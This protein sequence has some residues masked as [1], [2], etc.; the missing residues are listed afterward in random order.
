V[1][2]DDSVMLLRK[3]NP[4]VTVSVAV[5]DSLTEPKNTNELETWSVAVADSEMFDA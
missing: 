4:P 2:T 3:N 5:A 1:A